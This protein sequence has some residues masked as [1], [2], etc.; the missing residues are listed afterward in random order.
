MTF[1]ARTFRILSFR[2]TAG[3]YPNEG[4]LWPPFRCTRVIRHRRVIMWHLL[5][6]YDVLYC[7]TFVFDFYR[8][9]ILPTVCKWCRSNTSARRIC[10]TSRMKI[11]IA[12]NIG[13]KNSSRYQKLTCQLTALSHYFAAEISLPNADQWKIPVGEV[14]FKTKY[15]AVI[16][17]LPNT[18]CVRSLF[19][20]LSKWY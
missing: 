2:E 17:K 6:C 19:A 18:V 20:R 11:I 1:D 3:S 9:F 14:S 5:K 13:C 15:S 4:R 7:V 10:K 16:Y 8:L 12:K